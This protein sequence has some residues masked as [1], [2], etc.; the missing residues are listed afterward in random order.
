[1]GITALLKVE[2]ERPSGVRAENGAQIPDATA[3]DEALAKEPTYVV[4]RPDRGDSHPGFQLLGVETSFVHI[5]GTPHLWAIRQLLREAPNLTT[6]RITPK[7]MRRFGPQQRELC[8]THKIR[9][10]KGYHDSPVSSGQRGKPRP[11]YLK[12]RRF[13]IGLSGEKGE[14]FRE[15]IRRGFVEALLTARY[16]CLNGESYASLPDVA[17]EFGLGDERIASMKITGLR[18]FLDPRQK[19]GERPRDVARVVQARINRIHAIQQARVEKERRWRSMMWYARQLGVVH[20]PRDIRP[21]RRPVFKLLWQSQRDGRL[22][23]LLEDY[24]RSWQAIT[25]GYGLEDGNCRTQ[26]QAASRLALT[27]AGV[28]Y[29]QTRAIRILRGEIR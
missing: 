9:V 19:V 25:F 21:H 17:L 16:Y 15:L 7:M 18:Y 1:M 12:Q 28:S 22:D 2:R 3:I 23:L 27:K 13:Y 6:L 24:P 29:L 11:Q 14:L 26:S 8:S 4:L 10:V 5:A 20:V